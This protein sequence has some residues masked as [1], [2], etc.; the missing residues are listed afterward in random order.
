MKTYIT[1]SILELIFNDCM[2][3]DTIAFIDGT[4]E[5]AT[6][7]VMIRNQE[8]GREMEFTKDQEEE[9]YRIMEFT[10]ISKYRVMNINGI[11]YLDTY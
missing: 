3:K 1:R 9:F 5:K 6:P 10:D 7:K 2:K 11:I 4:K 8:T